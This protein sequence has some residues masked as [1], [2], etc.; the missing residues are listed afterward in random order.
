MCNKI[1]CS[2]EDYL[3]NFIQIPEDKYEELI[4]NY[5]SAIELLRA[6]LYESVIESEFDDDIRNFLKRVHKTKKV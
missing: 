2:E 5:E 1:N 3:N 6:V 4:S